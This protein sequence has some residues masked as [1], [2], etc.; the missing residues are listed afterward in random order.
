MRKPK[1]T[2]T[3]VIKIHLLSGKSITTWEAIQLYRITCLATRISELRRLGLQIEQERIDSD[4]THW[5]VYWL[6]SGYIQSYM[7]NGDEN[8]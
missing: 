7:A 8:E 3:Q 2:Q 6:D 5:Q 4:D 1:I